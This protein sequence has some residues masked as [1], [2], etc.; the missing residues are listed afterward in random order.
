MSA[1]GFQ[2]VM[3]HLIR[4]PEAS[5]DSICAQL[6]HPNLTERERGQL[7]KMENDPLVR[8]FGSKM[9]Y[10]RK[11]DALTVLPLSK[12]RM[13][14]ALIDELFHHRFEASTTSTDF[15]MIG[16]HFAEFLLSDE[17]SRRMISSGCPSYVP[18]LLR[19]ELAKA[20]IV[21]QRI[22]Q[23]DPALPAGSRLAHTS[24][25]IVDLHYDIPAVDRARNQGKGNPMEPSLRRM[26]LLFVR[27]SVRPFYRMFQVDEGLSNFLEA[28][29][30]SPDTWKQD[31]PSCLG[32]LITLGLCR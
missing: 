25:R 11:R 29:R 16:V 4:F 13:P 18:D 20:W 31:S 21:R 12:D 3:A 1:G 30:D 14:S 32:D 6:E 27:T 22:L 15:V 8:K 24:F 9:R 23:P 10:C 26:K 28:Q 2:K 7:S 19:Y 17:T 5:L